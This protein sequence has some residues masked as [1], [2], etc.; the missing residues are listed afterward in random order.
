VGVN[1]V[2]DRAS[3]STSA[4]VGPSILQST[5]VNVNLGLRREGSAWSVDRFDWSR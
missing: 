4:I 2:G 3:V 5:S 1:I